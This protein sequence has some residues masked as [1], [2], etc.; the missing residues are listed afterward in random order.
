MPDVASTPPGAFVAANGID[1][2]YQEA[3][4]GPPLVLLHGG[5]AS[6]HSCWETFGWGWS[7]YLDELA[8]A[9]RV[10]APDLRGHGWT[11]NSTGSVS[12]DLLA[13]DLL[14]FIR[15]LGLDRPAVVGFSDGGIMAAVLAIK[16]PEALSA[17]VNIAGYDLFDPAAVATA[18]GADSQ[19]ELVRNDRAAHGHA[20]LV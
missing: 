11:R 9:F 15:A 17:L 1:V 7:R 10:L 18:P 14:A 19:P 6:N 16:E 12:Y 5:S 4:I 20:T 3:G 13:D 2:H 8:L